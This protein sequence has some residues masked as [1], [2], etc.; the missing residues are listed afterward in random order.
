MEKH[1]R[2]LMMGRME[3]LPESSRNAMQ[4]AIDKTAD[5]DGLTVILAISYSGRTELARAAQTIAMEA[6]NGMLA[7]E[8]ITSET[9]SQHLYLNS[10]P[11]PDILI[12]T[13]GE[14][15]ISNFLLWQL[16]YTEFFFLP[17]MWPDFNKEHLP[18][19]LI[20]VIHK[21]LKFLFFAFLSR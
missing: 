11:D 7:P 12:R 2:M 3:D 9:I 18:P 15:R 16:A 14:C 10:V 19:A 1:V 5:N 4:Y 8:D 20:R 17:V 6:K 21:L 13:G